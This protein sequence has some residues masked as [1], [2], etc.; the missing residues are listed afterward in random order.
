MV[1]DDVDWEDLV[2]ETLVLHQVKDEEIETGHYNT[3]LD[4]HK[5]LERG[6]VFKHT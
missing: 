1:V 4:L 3:L 5:I 6:D 2:I